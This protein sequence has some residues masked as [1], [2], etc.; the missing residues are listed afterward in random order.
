[1]KKIVVKQKLISRCQ[2]E[3]QVFK[4]QAAAQ[5]HV[6]WHAYKK[7]RNLFIDKHI[8]FL[9]HKA[10]KSIQYLF[11]NQYALSYFFLL[12]ASDI[13]SNPSTTIVKT[14]FSNFVL[15]PTACLPFPLAC[16]TTYMTSWCLASL[17]PVSNHSLCNQLQTS[18]KPL[19]ESPFNSTTP[20]YLWRLF[21]N[22]FIFQRGSGDLDLLIQFLL[23]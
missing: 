9:I 22:R 4:Q 14:P 23:S 8:L 15:P 5:S 3:A 2:K 13:H 19:Q 18:G 21:G 16:A 20:C 17:I 10:I 11:I 12:F 6:L 7:L 1:M